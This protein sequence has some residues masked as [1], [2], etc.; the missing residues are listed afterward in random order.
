MSTSTAASTPPPLSPGGCWR[1]CE[2][3]EAA[4]TLGCLAVADA[5]EPHDR[6]LVRARS[7]DDRGR[8]LA[9]G[10]RGSQ[11]EQPRSRSGHVE[12]PVEPVGPADAARAQHRCRLVHLRLS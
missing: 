1:L 8:A 5:L 10:D 3:L 9:D 7:A 11:R 6:A 2:E 4:Q 12:A